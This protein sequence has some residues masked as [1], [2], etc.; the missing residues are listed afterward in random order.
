MSNPRQSI[1][2]RRINGG[3]GIEKHWLSNPYRTCLQLLILHVHSYTCL[4]SPHS[5]EYFIG[6]PSKEQ[7]FLQGLSEPPL[8]NGRHKFQQ[9]RYL[10]LGG[11][12]SF[13]SL[14]LIA[15]NILYPK[16]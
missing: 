3:F 7:L 15:K 14:F 13:F 12:N 8:K 2:E 1:R 9:S 16:E 5:S 4:N 6:I 11:A 10:S